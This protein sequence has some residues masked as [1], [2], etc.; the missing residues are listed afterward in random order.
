MNATLEDVTRKN[1]AE[2]TAEAIAAEEIVRQ[3]ETALNQE[4]TGAWT[5]RSI[6]R[7]TFLAASL[8][9]AP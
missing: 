8:A 2:L 3:A 5:T 1:K 7:T 4:R 6:T 9:G